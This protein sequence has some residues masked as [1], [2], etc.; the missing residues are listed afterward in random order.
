V[1]NV[2]YWSSGHLVRPV[3]DYKVPNLK[4]I[5]ETDKIVNR[6]LESSKYSL[7]VFLKVFLNLKSILEIYPC[8]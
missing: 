5:L 4:S 7:T 3:W 2:Q 1:D 6:I 8:L